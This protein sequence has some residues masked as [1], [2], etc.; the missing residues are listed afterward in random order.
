MT[1]R[2]VVLLPDVP[3]DEPFIDWFGVPLHREQFEGENTLEAFAGTSAPQGGNVDHG[4]QTVLMV[5]DLDATAFTSIRVLM[6]EDAETPSGFAVILG[7]DSEAATFA[8]A[9]EFAAKTIRRQLK[10][11]HAGQG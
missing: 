10:Q 7:G 3:Q 1:A 4:A 2:D 5:S 6:H 9:L 8:D 11:N